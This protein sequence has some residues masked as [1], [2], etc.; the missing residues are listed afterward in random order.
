MIWIETKNVD[1][2]LRS[3]QSEASL[4]FFH[5][6]Q[7]SWNTTVESL[8]ASLIKARAKIPQKKL[9]AAVKN[10]RGRIERVISAE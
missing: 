5:A 8:K 3:N 7:Q 2:I 6:F 1:N 9:R 4:F 10:F